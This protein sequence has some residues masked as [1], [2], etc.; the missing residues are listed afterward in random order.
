MAIIEKIKRTPGILDVYNTNGHW[1][2][3]ALLDVSDIIELNNVI[4]TIRSSEGIAK[5]ETF[6]MLG[7]A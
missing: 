3:I 6:I 7:P 4:S 5:S 2:I 1:D